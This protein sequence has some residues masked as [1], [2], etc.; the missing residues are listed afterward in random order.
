MSPY[1][2][3]IENSKL[4][5]YKYNELG[6]QKF[7]MSGVPVIALR[8]ETQELLSSLLNPEKIFPADNKL[9]RDWRGL[10]E[11]CGVGGELMRSFQISEDKTKKILKTWSQKNGAESTIDKL[12][13]FLKDLDRYDVYDD[14][15]PYVER[16]IEYFNSNPKDICGD[17][18][19]DDVDG[20][21]ILTYDDSLRHMDG[22]PPQTYD[23][24]LL[25]DDQD[26]DFATNI[27]NTLEVQHNMKLCVK[28]RDLV[29]GR[30]EHFSVIKLI[31]KRCRK[32]I[33]VVS[34]SFW[35][36]RTNK[37]FYS[38]AQLD[39]L[40]KRCSKIIPCS[41]NPY[42]P[43]EVPIEFQVYHTLVFSRSFGKFWERLYQAVRQMPAPPKIITPASQEV[44]RTIQEK[45]TEAPKKPVNHVKFN[46]V[47][48]SEEAEQSIDPSP[49]E[50]IPKSISEDISLTN[51]NSSAEQPETLPEL[52][53]KKF[54]SKILRFVNPKTKKQEAE[55]KTQ[56]D[57]I[58]KKKS[59]SRKKVAVA[60][61]Q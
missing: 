19:D 48:D 7:D 51:N 6:A 35:S 39:N 1:E 15:T 11:L 5:N 36:S 26:I 8:R 38:L 25:F 46:T 60:I 41:N 32:V 58:H 14:I 50:N 17:L 37:Y 12:L 4:Y 2:L 47:D 24:F 42:K 53:K 27:I 57:D 33:V 34:P 29:G 30:L 16:D 52:K 21:D 55:K 13:S 18:S 20:Q 22:L 61:A 10:A 9:P 23:A 56:A 3:E 31:S 43:S 54:F 44:E 28:D 49:E 40:E 45:S 59:S